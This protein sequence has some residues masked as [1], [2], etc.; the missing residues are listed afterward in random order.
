MTPCAIKDGDMAASFNSPMML[1]TPP[2]ICVGC[3]R[4]FA[5]LGIPDPAG[6]EKTVGDYIRKY[7]RR[8][9]R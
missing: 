4:S 7:E 6:W 3:N 1:E 8:A 9:R 2:P 5:K